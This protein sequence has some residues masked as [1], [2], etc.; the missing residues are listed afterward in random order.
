[1]AFLAA[2][3]CDRRTSALQH[4]RQEDV[5]FPE[6]L[7]AMQASPRSLWAVGRLPAATERL[8]AIV[9]ARAATR[10]GCDRAA[11]LAAELGREG[12]AVVSG[13]AFGIDAAAHEGAL[14]VGAATFAVLGCGADVVYPDRHVGLFA[15]IASSGGLLSEYPPGTPPRAGQFPV[16]NRI[17]A[18]LSE[19]VIVV[20]AAMRS[21]AL[22]TTRL[23]GAM[24]RLVLA[25]PG[26]GGTDA[27]LRAGHALPVT[28]AEDILRALAGERRP[29][30]VAEPMAGPLA[31]ILHAISL[32]AS[33]PAAICRKLGVGLPHVLAILAE[34]ELDG[35]VERAAGNIYEVIARAC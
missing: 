4:V 28:T 9:G 20:E 33:T 2:Q 3:K 10:A 12:I 1:M 29:A 14:S 32:G 22:I 18:A 19:A 15:R 8:L 5:R 24:G 30:P 11:A 7:R 17:I 23:G 34:A 16:R 31:E 13:G 21:G 35:F 6:Q 26:S 27:L 25:V